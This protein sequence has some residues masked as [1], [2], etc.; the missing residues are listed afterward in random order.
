METGDVAKQKHNPTNNLK[1]KITE[2]RQY[3]IL[4]FDDASPFAHR[5]IWYQ[6][7]YLCQLHIMNKSK[8]IT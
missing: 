4:N 6:E 2:K 1:K 7:E 3:A 5:I 8:D